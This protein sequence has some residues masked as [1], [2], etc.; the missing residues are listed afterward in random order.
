MNKLASAILEH[1]LPGG[2]KITTR[3]SASSETI[4]ELRLLLDGFALA[5]RS[6]S[7]PE[8]KRKKKPCGCK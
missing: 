1:P 8:E 6:E 3:V 4:Y 5:K 2:G 7:A